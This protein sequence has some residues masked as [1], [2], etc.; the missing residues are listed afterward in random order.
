M[1]TELESADYEIEIDGVE[2]YVY[3]DIIWGWENDGIGEYE[4]HGQKCYDEGSWSS[5]VEDVVI[6]SIHHINDETDAELQVS[7]EIKEKIIQHIFQTA[8][9]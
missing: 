4:Y 2:Y 7:D 6:K 8:K 5:S 9:Y 3:F 1:K